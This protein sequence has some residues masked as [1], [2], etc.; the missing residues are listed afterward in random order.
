MRPRLRRNHAGVNAPFPVPEHREDPL[1]IAA[2][3]RSLAR[4]LRDRGFATADLDAR[5]I[6]GHALGLDHSA[7]ANAVAQCARAS[8]IACDYAAAMNGPV[9][10]VVSN[11]PYIPLPQIANLQPEVRLF[12]PRLALDGGPDGLDGYRAIA[13]DARRILAPD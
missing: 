2:S 8:F 4:K 10:V 13:T 9:D 11:P 12:D 5:L 1:S 7:R 3:R 6:V